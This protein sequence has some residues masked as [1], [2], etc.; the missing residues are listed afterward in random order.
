M[1]AHFEPLCGADETEV[2]KRTDCMV[3][4]AC[5]RPSVLFGAGTG[6]LDAKPNAR[7]RG[8]IGRRHL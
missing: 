4:R 6:S 2:E 8:E 1:R 3:S 7:A 5:V